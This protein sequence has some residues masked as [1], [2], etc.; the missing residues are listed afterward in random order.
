M[1][2]PTNPEAALAA[3][4]R[5]ADYCNAMRAIERL[6]A[7]CTNRKAKAEL[8]TAKSAFSMA[9]TYEYVAGKVKATA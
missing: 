7:S 4:T 8:R 2:T 5:S 1:T 6:L 9:H 3:H